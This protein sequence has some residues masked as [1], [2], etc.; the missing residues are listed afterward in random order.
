MKKVFNK[1][2]TLFASLVLTVGL[3][4]DGPFAFA[5]VKV[6]DNPET[7]HEGSAL[8]IESG[9]KGLLLPRVPLFKTDVWGLDGTPVAGMLIYNTNSDM[10]GT[11]AYPVL[12]PQ[13]SGVYSWDGNGWVGVNYKQA[14]VEEFHWLKIGENTNLIA[15]EDINSNI[16]HNGNVGIGTIAP[17]SSL[18]VTG[19][20]T[21]AT[22]SEFKEFENDKIT[23]GNGGIDIW[24]EYNDGGN[25]DFNKGTYDDHDQTASMVYWPGIGTEG[26][27]RIS[28]FNAVDKID[29]ITILNENGNVGIDKVIPKYKLDIKGDIN[30]DGKVRSGGIALTSDARLKRNIQTLDNG[31]DIVSKLKPV[32]YEKKASI[33]NSDY[34]KKEIGLIA[35]DVQKTLPELVSEGKD[36][37]KTLAL[38]YNSL[39]PILTRAIQEQQVLIEKMSVERTNRNSKLVYQSSQLEM[40]A[41]ELSK[42]S[43]EIAEIK[44]VIATNKKAGG[45]NSVEH[46]TTK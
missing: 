42:Q 1:H 3:A 13:G 8:E 44:R 30:G 46:I 41:S 15:P 23:I 19:V 20:I 31:L 28:V 39:I 38:D 10:F 12:Q 17:S 16:Y 27:L 5:Q 33:T 36:P 11:D 2:I 6:G 32:S 45:V 24:D 34:N 4:L 25:V 43:D 29:A 21:Q 40:Q 18:Q 14:S 35:Q 22:Y 26:V 9:N 37:D 7:M